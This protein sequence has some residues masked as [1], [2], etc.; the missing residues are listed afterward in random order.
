VKPGIAFRI[1]FGIGLAG[2]LGVSP[3][4][5]GLII[6]RFDSKDFPKPHICNSFPTPV[7]INFSILI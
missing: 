4:Y 3:F 1:V 6:C 7:I 2:K 5:R